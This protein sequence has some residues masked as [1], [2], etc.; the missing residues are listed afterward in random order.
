LQ[1]GK[2]A[3]M[4]KCVQRFLF[5]PDAP[6]APAVAPAL[7]EQPI[8]FTTTQPH[9]TMNGTILSA[10]ALVRIPNGQ[11]RTI[12]IIANGDAQSVAQAYAYLYTGLFQTIG[13]Y[14]QIQGYAVAH[15]TIHNDVEE[16]QILD[17]LL[18][19]FWGVDVVDTRPI[20]IILEA[21]RP[22]RN[23]AV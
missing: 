7:L 12:E 2:S 11:S 21:P 6:D 18:Y 23:G 17:E 14:N 22:P 16:Q 13:Y 1:K 9:T 19:S 15:I 4:P 5:A 8:S 20:R 3:A 10:P